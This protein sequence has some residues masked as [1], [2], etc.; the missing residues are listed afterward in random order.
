ML[1][2]EPINGFVV[3]WFLSLECSLWSMEANE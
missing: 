1:M 3:I 2:T